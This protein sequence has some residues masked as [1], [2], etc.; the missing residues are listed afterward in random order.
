MKSGKDA[1]YTEAELIAGCLKDKRSFQEALYRRFADAMYR[2]AWTYTKD[3]DEACDVLQEAFINVFRHLKK[4][5]Q[6]GSLEGWIRRIVVNK[7]LEHY[8]AK[9]RKFEVED[10][11]NQVQDQSLSDE[12]DGLSS[13]EIIQQ[14]NSLP[15]KAALV[16]KLYAIEGYAHQEIAEA[17]GISEGTSKSQLSR[18]RQ[19]LKGKFAQ[20]DG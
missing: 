12:R 9:R 5:K 7:A 6:D 16:L 13:E 10:A 4:F 18:A 11:Y 2:V 19:L 15:E 20:L 3:E 8:R 17:L 1:E 14:V